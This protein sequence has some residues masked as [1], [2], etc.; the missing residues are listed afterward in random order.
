M[1]VLYIGLSNHIRGIAETLSGM[2]DD[3]HFVKPGE[4]FSRSMVAR[5]ILDTQNVD[6]IVTAEAVVNQIPQSKIIIKDLRGHGSRQPILGLTNCFS[7]RNLSEFLEAGG[8]VLLPFRRS[9]SGYFTF[10]ADILRSQIG[11][12]VTVAKPNVQAET[13]NGSGLTVNLVEPTQHISFAGFSLNKAGDFSL[14]DNRL[15]LSPRQQALME[16][17]I[18]A[19]F[20][21]VSHGEVQQSAKHQTIGRTTLSTD[22]FRLRRAIASN[23]KLM[24]HHFASPLIEPIRRK[25]WRFNA[26]SLRKL[27]ALMAPYYSVPELSRHSIQ[28]YGE[29]RQALKYPDFSVDI[30]EKKLCFRGVPLQL[31]TSCSKVLIELFRAEGQVVSSDDLYKRCS[32]LGGGTKKAVTTD[33]IMRARGRLSEEFDRLG[34]SVTFPLIE[35]VG[36][37]GWVISEENIKRLSSLKL[38]SQALS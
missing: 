25:G 17:F 35:T 2:S 20:D 33:A 24:G 6:L 11:Q 36:R 28:L 23:I 26:S 4:V 16:I 27:H 19:G 7:E 18:R 5:Q 13:P 37:K 21:T 12:L 22:I 1:K 9:E 32:Q 34:L 15:H 3:V 29:T 38:H 31:P 10:R 8:N 14:Y 30:D